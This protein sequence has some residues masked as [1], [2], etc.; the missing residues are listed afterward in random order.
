MTLQGKG[1]YIWRIPYCENGDVTAIANLAVQANLTHILVKIA[2]GIYSYNIDSKTGQDLVPPLVTALRARKIQVYGWQ[3]CY[4]DDPLGEADKAIQ[5]V[6]QLN[7]DGYVVDA[8]SEYKQPGKA[9][10]AS[11]FMSR[12]RAGLGALPVGLSS[13]RFP[14]YHPEFPWKEFLEK[15][16]I[17]LPQV[18]WIRAHNPSEQLTRC[19]QEFQALTPYRPIVPTGSAFRYGTWTPTKEDITAFL[20]TAQALN[21]TGANFWEWS[22]CRTNLPELWETIRDYPWST[23]PPGDDITQRLIAALNTHQVDQVASLYQPNAVH[24]NAARTVQGIAAIKSWYSSMFTQLLP[25]GRFT[26]TAFSGSGNSRHFN[27]IA[28]SR[29][30]N[31]HNGS[32]TLGLMD[33]KIYYHYTFFTIT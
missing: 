26:L 30:G 33:G 2:D 19:V 9:Q 27:W 22:N 15:C 1:F 8:E 25:E 7:L 29:A 14:S 20:Q 11:Q 12:L 3:Y 5:R 13:Y 18:Y 24:V 28:T 31:V 10:A 32:D 21:L 6:Q 4:G 17:N 16:D 23:S